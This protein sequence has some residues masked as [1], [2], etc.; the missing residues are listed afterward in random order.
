[1]RPYKFWAN[2][3]RQPVLPAARTWDKGSTMPCADLT[4]VRM[5]Y[6]IAG[7]GA[8]L[9]LLPGLGTTCQIWKPILEDLSKHFSVICLD[10][11]GI[12][13]SQARRPPRTLRAYSADLIELLEHLQIGRAHLMGL[14]LGGM[15]AQR[16]AIDH[17]E[18]VAR[19]VLVSCTHSFT[20]YLREIAKLIGQIL[21]WF[22]QPV[23][24]RTMEILGSGPFFLDTNPQRISERVHQMRQM[25]LSSSAVVRQLRALRASEFVLEQYRI[26]A[27]T[28]FL[29]GE[30]DSLI[31]HCYARRTA[32]LIDNCR[33]MLIR[34]S[35]HN[36]F[37]DC[38]ESV[39]PLVVEFLRAGGTGPADDLGNKQTESG[40]SAQNKSVSEQVDQQVA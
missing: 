36:P 3:G 10:N 35:G 25:H 32:Q 12:G 5:Y 16:F 14:S 7:D 31:P 30:F 15:I 26:D 27:P 1:M 17:P 28:L 13:Q 33:F 9:V 38:P 20:P 40:R 39:L 37:N 11:R 2:N 23:F 18:C 4:D 34:D 19:M 24:A 6:E 21:R 8:P 29:A 22:P